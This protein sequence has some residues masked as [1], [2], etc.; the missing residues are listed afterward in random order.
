M[1]CRIFLAAL[2]VLAG[3]AV[4]A[5]ANSQI[6]IVH[7]FTGKADGFGPISPT[8]AGGTLYVPT[9]GAGTGKIFKL[10]PSGGAWTK[11]L[12]QSFNATTGAH[13]S[14][15]VADAAG[16]LYGVTT[17]GG[18]GLCTNAKKTPKVIG[19]GIVYKLTPATGKNAD[20]K[21]WIRT[22]LYQFTNTGDG[23]FPAGRLLMDASGAL[24]GVTSP[25]PAYGVTNCAPRC[26]GI[27]QLAPPAAEGGAWT[28]RTLYTFTGAPDGEGPT[29]DL[30]ADAN[31][32]LY[33][34]TRSGGTFGGAFGTGTVFSLTPPAS[35][36]GSW[37]ETVLYRF[38]PAN[39]F[40]GAQPMSGVILGAGGALYGTTLHGGPDGAGTVY[41]LTPPA[42]PGGNW[43][44]SI[45]HAFS[46]NADGCWPVG[47]LVA[48]RAGQ[49]FGTTANCGLGT[50]GTAFRLT[51]PAVAGD[52]WTKTVLHNFSGGAPDSG[53]PTATLVVDQNG[54]LY[55]S[56]GAGL[57]FD[58]EY[59]ATWA[60]TNSGFAP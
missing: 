39:K 38:L 13:P 5:P 8:L 46:N 56:T 50:S 58:G 30:I 53:Q 27:F 25:V 7:T 23:A 35:P 43:T 60:I 57:G 4:A 3:L 44:Q 32:V 20:R 55:G 47:G 22:V 16:A 45:L 40:T 31:G 11:T 34:T 41:Q 12:I 2:S 36:G 17:N 48:D 52:P 9:G 33:G 6:E 54:K 59:G 21:K 42:S 15:L 14:P 29:G 49:L 19:C 10:A 18:T 37:T 28:A 51:P 1:G 24:Y 26:G